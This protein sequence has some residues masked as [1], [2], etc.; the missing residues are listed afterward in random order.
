MRLFFRRALF[1]VSVFFLLC[2]VGVVPHSVAFALGEAEQTPR[3][4]S[5]AQDA[6]E[7]DDAVFPVARQ[8]IT[9][10]SADVRVHLEEAKARAREQG[11]A[12]SSRWRRLLFITPG[13]FSRTKSVVDSDTFFFSP[14]GRTRPAEELLASLEAMFHGVTD[15]AA[16]DVHPQCR[17][18][19]RLSFF[20][21]TLA[22][23]EDLLPRPD[24]AKFKTWFSNTRGDGASLVFSSYYLN[25]PSSMF[26]H[27]FVRIHRLPGEGAAG[28]RGSPLLDWSVSFAAFP[29]TK[30]PLLYAVL[31]LAG[32]FPGRFSMMPH[33]VKAQEYN[34]HESRD[35]W[36]Y[37]LDINEDG[38]S[39]MLESLWE[40]GNEHI[41][42]Y[43]FDDNCAYIL[44][45]LIE[46]AREDVDLTSHFYFWVTPS[47]TVRV[48]ARVPGL[49]KEVSYRPSNMSRLLERWEALR[50]EGL[51]AR[52]RAFAVRF[53]K[54]PEAFPYDW[55]DLSAEAKARVFDVMLE[56]IDFEE[57]LALG[58]E[59][60]SRWAPIRDRVLR[61][62]AEL[63]VVS[64]PLARK[65][66]SERPDL[67]HSTNRV[68]LTGGFSSPLSSSA[69]TGEP[70]GQFEWR[71]SLHDLLAPGVGYP[72]GMQLDFFDLVLRYQD[73]KA[74]IHSLDLIEIVSAQPSTGLLS[75]WS[76]RFRM[77]T[78]QRGA[79]AGREG[80]CFVSG[81]DAGMGLTVADEART[82]LAYALPGI[83]VG[84][85]GERNMTFYGGPNAVAGVVLKPADPL[86]IGLRG[87]A[88]RRFGVQGQALT[89]WEVRTDAAVSLSTNLET[90]LGLSYGE[91]APQKETLEASLSLFLYYE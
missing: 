46:I 42:Y 54:E 75:P 74:T 53:A 9:H 90:R 19:G 58:K 63:R 85:S 88:V 34:N 18:P 3:T 32:G 64:P 39:R 55:G 16:A 36:E 44:L 10:L 66:E 33:Y 70:F 45:A 69:H 4:A 30:N 43:Y 50:K 57:K 38:V 21:Q 17:F 77:G 89:D 47:D 61:A 83:D 27:T 86:R 40:I 73:E 82:V 1:M 62:R 87:Q 51:D 71:P 29:T 84:F 6:P 79:C 48:V 37:A 49:V 81:I 35:L 12:E 14:K 68:G 22:L 56:H 60:G 26:G 11:L 23:R 52:E 67:G 15:Y 78:Q 72:P 91:R 65:P 28:A 41:D 8:R 20:K 31:G 25:N 24:C 5:G 13:W 76:W 2:V 80:R 59:P 7:V